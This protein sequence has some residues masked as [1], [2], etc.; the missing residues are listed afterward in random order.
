M[1][2]D[3]AFP[4]LGGGDQKLALAS[5]V[6]SQPGTIPAAASPRIPS[7]SCPSPALTLCAA[8]AAATAAAASRASLKGGK[9]APPARSSSDTSPASVSAAT[10]KA[11]SGRLRAR[12]MSAPSPSAGKMYALFAWLGRNEPPSASRTSGKGLPDANRQRPRVCAN[13]SSAVHSE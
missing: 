9:S 3:R 12:A 11:S 1:R 5:C 13:A 2:A 8:T 7:A 10:R 4:G 6:Q